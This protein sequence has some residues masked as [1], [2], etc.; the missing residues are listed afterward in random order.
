M[1]W[2][3]K[4][5][6]E[7]AD[8]AG[9]IWKWDFEWDGGSGETAMT[10]SGDPA[11][12][13]PLAN[14]DDLFENPVRGT[15]ATLRVMATSSFQYVDF[16]TLEDLE[17]RVSIYYGS[18]LYFRGYVLPMSYSEPYNDFP[19]EVTITAICGLGAL[20]NIKYDNAGTPYTGRKYESQILLD[21]LAKI[22]ATQ[23][24][25]IINIYEDNMDDDTGD[26]PLDQEKIDVS[27]FDDMYC[28][29]VLE[30]LLNKWNA[31]IRQRGGEFFIYRPTEM[32]DTTYYRTFTAATTKSGSSISSVAKLLRS[33]SATADLRDHNGGAMM[34]IPPAKKLTLTLDYGHKESWFSKWDFLP[35]DFDGATDTMDGWDKINSADLNMLHI[36]ELLVNEKQGLAINTVDPYDPAGI[37]QI[38]TLAI[39]STIDKF[40]LSFEFGWFND[41]GSGVTASN[42]LVQITCGAYYLSEVDDTTAE[43]TLTPTSISILPVDVL[44][45]ATVPDGWA[46]W[47]EYIREVV[48]IPQNGDIEVKVMA[49]IYGDVYNC[50]KYMKFY[51]SSFAA[52]QYQK[53]ASGKLIRRERQSAE[54]VKWNELYG[55]I[56]KPVEVMLKEYIIT[57]ALNGIEKADDYL[58]GD[59][60]DTGIDNILNQFA[61]SL[62]RSLATRTKVAAKF[63]TDWA[64]TYLV[65]GVVVTSDGEDIIFTSNTPGVAFTG[66]TTITDKSGDLDGSVANTQANVTAQTEIDTVT[67]TGTGGTANITCNGVTRLATFDFDI[68]T[69]CSNFETAWAAAFDAAGVILFAGL[70]MSMIFEA[71]VTGTPFS[72]NTTI[73]NVSGNLTGSKEDTQANRVA[74]AQIDTVTLTG[75]SGTAD[76]LCDA[77]TKEATFDEQPTAT[78]HTRGNAEGE[79]LLQITGAEQG[80]QMA[81]P[82]QM[83]AGFPVYDLDVNDTD[84]HVDVIGCFEDDLNQTGG[85]NR[86]FAFN[87]GIFDMKNRHWDID[88]IEIVE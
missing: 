69:T 34:L 15:K 28:Y 70:N 63:V 40:V 65:G 77:V 80:V 64:A 83:L 22:G 76:I 56:Y 41:S 3:T 57:N 73:V 31:L 32:A 23:F 43:W 29:E 1:A 16:Y 84:P 36:S 37:S 8:K 2:G 50:Y 9:L 46:G 11:T 13:E 20:K 17:V 6:C 85:N 4:Y 45:S 54:S 30:K 48:G 19:Y 62:S 27:I 49:Q 21:I 78:W 47:F 42:I 51:C 82:R 87:K 86:V 55:L 53:S 66:A 52:R 79:A 67:I 58:N 68:A 38:R 81:R 7:F 26:S 60:S 18:T 33:T 12:Y 10:A 72:G 74:V 71:K 44:G 25:E 61:G 88:L 59:V 35:E 24:T 75:A 14:A 5:R 39:Y